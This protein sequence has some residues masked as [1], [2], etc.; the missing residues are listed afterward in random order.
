MRKKNYIINYNNDEIIQCIVIFKVV[1]LIKNENI[2]LKIFAKFSNY[3]SWK[4]IL[5]NYIK[6]IA[7]KNKNKKN[8]AKIINIMKKE[9][10]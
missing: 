4:K 8:N 2:T 6:T 5:R 10:F 1:I 7:K 3:F 9:K